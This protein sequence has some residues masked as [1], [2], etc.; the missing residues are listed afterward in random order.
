MSKILK[1][2]MFRIGGSTNGGI[3]S[4]VVPKRAGYQNPTG[5]AVTE[6]NYTLDVN[7]PLYKDAMKKAAI[8]S[9]FAGPGRSERDRL[10]D[11]LLQGSIKLASETPRG[12]I[13]PTIAKSFEQPVSEY[14]KAGESEDTFKRQLRL[15]AATQAMASQ[16]AQEKYKKELEIANQKLEQQEKELFFKTSGLG[17][18]APGIYETIKTLKRKGEVVEGGAVDI[19]NKKPK[20]S[21]ILKIPAGT[22]FYDVTGNF[23]KRTKE[24]PGYIRILTSGEAVPTPT[25]TKQLGFFEKAKEE[26]AAYDPRSWNKRR[27]YEEL[28]KKNPTSTME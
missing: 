4:N 17:T 28:A 9:Q 18:K 20:T 2:P 22:V 27:F 10:L 14:L 12:G 11:L 7:D 25:V 21:D 3:M 13:I 1:R 6:D 5:A 8:L 19:E 24:G 16:E 26:G 15:A 23:Y